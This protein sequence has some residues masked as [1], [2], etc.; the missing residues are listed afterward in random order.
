MREILG[1]IPVGRRRQR[2]DHVQALAAGGAHEG[3]QTQGP[4]AV[5]QHAG[6]VDD[7][8]ERQLRRWVQI[9]HQ[10][11]ALVRLVGRRAPGMELDHVHLH[12][13]LDA[14][15]AV[16][17][18][19]VAAAVLFLDR[20][21]VHVLA[22]ALAAMFL[23]EVLTVDSV[24]AAQ[25]RQRAA[26]DLGQQRLGH[27]S[28][29]V[30]DIGLAQAGV[31]KHHA[32]RM[33]QLEVGDLG[34]RRFELLHGLVLAQGLECGLAQQAEAGDVAVADFRDQFRPHPVRLAG[35]AFGQA[36]LTDRRGLALQLLQF[37][38]QRTQQR[39]RKSGAD[40]TDVMPAAVGIRLGEQ[41]RAEA[42]A[43]ALGLG[44]ADDGE[45]V[46]VLALDLAPVVAATGAIGTV[47]TFAD[48]AFEPE[49]FGGGEH[50]VAVA[51]VMLAVGEHA[52]RLARQ[53][54]AQALLA[55]AQRLLA[56]VFPVQARQV[57]QLIAERRLG[58][59]C[60]AGLQRI[61][62]TAAAAQHHQFAVEFGIVGVEFAQRL[63]DIRQAL[64]PVQAVAG[65]QPRFA[66]DEG[67]QQPVA[68]PLG[69]VQPLPALGR[70]AHK[71]GELRVERLGL[72]GRFR[73]YGLP[74]RCPRG[75][76]GFAGSEVS[77]GVGEIVRLARAGVAVAPLD[78]QPLRLLAVHAR[79]HEIPAAMQH[80]AVE[81]E[82]D[83]TLVELLLR[84]AF[85]CPVAFVED[86]HLAGA[87]VAFRDLAFE[88]GVV[89]RMILDLHG[90]TLGAG[91]ETRSLGNRPTFEHAVHLQAEVV[92]P[93]AGVMQLHHETRPAAVPL[94]LASGARFRRAFPTLFAIGLD[95]HADLLLADLDDFLLAAFLRVL[96]RRVLPR[97]LRP[98]G[99]PRF[100]DLRL[101]RSRAMKSSS[102]PDG[103]ASSSMSSG[104][105]SPSSLT[106][107]STRLRSR[108]RKSS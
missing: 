52:A 12:Q 43:A 100:F 56:Q 102:L 82:T 75:G 74:L 99:L 37:R 89:Q 64:G 26:D 92:M 80:P 103:G 18:Q 1:R 58:A 39:V 69:F 61:E 45:L 94:A 108:S 44:V 14:L 50:G 47:R 48:D 32:V 53:Q 35:F 22:H 7:A 73:R 8:S 65:P 96:R 40:A 27:C 60:E 17:H 15:H 4:E 10:P 49:L 6:A 28:V 97:L 2:Y 34:H 36:G 16:D 62:V 55:L 79:T 23:E 54:F 51:G 5:A 63:D 46:R 84:I 66:V 90:Q 33:R 85:G 98:A 29:V 104:S 71:L 91:V 87:V 83:M 38:G 59:P 86:L 77:A 68:V 30:G 13:F 70:R 101:S 21:G 42:V 67:R 81:F 105:A 19:V 41:Q 88:A 25:H 76:L 95:A 93:A 78:Q 24:R 57:E 107:F 31:R 20:H 106:R 11:V 72:A 3:F 9:E